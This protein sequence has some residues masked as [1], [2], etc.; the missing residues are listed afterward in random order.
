MCTSG[1]IWTEMSLHSRQFNKCCSVSWAK[2]ITAQG[3]LGRN[4]DLTVLYKVLL[5]WT[6]ANRTTLML[7]VQPLKVTK[8]KNRY[9]IFSINQTVNTRLSN[10]SALSLNQEQSSKNKCDIMHYVGCAGGGGGGGVVEIL[11]RIGDIIWGGGGG[12]GTG[13][14]RWGNRLHRAVRHQTDG[15]LRGTQR[16]KVS[17]QRHSRRTTDKGQWE[18]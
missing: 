10:S 16:V 3:L 12:R 15:T 1:L 6:E 13:A 9:L 17:R 7:M 8:W 11:S 4:A 14:R 2:S 5:W 18:D